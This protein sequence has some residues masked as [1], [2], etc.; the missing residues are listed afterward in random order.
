[1]TTPSPATR[2]PVGVAL[3]SHLAPETLRPMSV[4]AEDLGFGEL[5]VFEDLWFTSGIS[6]AAIALGATREIPV[7]VS[8]V[9]AVS[10]HPSILALEI[11]TLARAFPGRFMPGVGL[12]FNVWLKQMGLLPRQQVRAVRE[13][14]S[15]VRALLDGQTV[16]FEGTAFSA[17]GIELHYPVADVPLYMGLFGPKMLEAAGEVADGVAISLTASPAYVSWARE[18]LRTAA[19]AAGRDIHHRLPTM[20]LCAVDEDGDKAR[21]E[22]RSS[23]A[24]YLGLMRNNALTDVYGISDHVR[25]ISEGGPEQVEREMPDE[26]IDD[27]AI[28]GTPDE[29]AAKIQRFLD[30][31]A[32]SVILYP[33][34]ATRTER[35]L[36]LAGEEILGRLR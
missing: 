8:I 19:A 6:G 17:S 25:A 10:R 30:A 33:V 23:L 34:P 9:G 18:G 13:C 26:W 15:T 1:M 16:D 2:P 28:A 36:R 32:D 14:V 24:W 3:G 29:C 31:G 11:S 12:G 22:M 35:V 7:G 5:W 21:A 4:L 20:A 27:L